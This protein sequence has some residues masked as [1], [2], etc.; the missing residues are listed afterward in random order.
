MVGVGGTVGAG[1]MVGSGVMVG[2]GVEVGSG[3]NIESA[4]EKSVIPGSP[5]HQFS[6]KVFDSSIDIGSIRPYRTPPELNVKGIS[7]E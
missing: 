2:V 1:V 6:H 7:P 3:R 5:T 4:V